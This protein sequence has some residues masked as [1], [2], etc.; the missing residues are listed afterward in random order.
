MGHPDRSDATFNPGPV[1]GFLIALGLFILWYFVSLYGTWLWFYEIKK[2]Y[3]LFALDFVIAVT[4]LGTIINLGFWRCVG[5][6]KPWEPSGINIDRKFFPN[7]AYGLLIGLGLLFAT[8]IIITWIFLISDSIILLI[9]SYE[10]A[11][12]GD[13]VAPQGWVA[14]V[15]MYFIY[16]FFLEFM[17][18]GLFYPLLKKSIGFIPA[19]L[20]GSAV[21]TLTHLGNPDFNILPAIGVLILGLISTLLRENTGSIWAGW[22]FNLSITMTS[23]AL[24][25]PISGTI[26]HLVPP[27]MS[28]FELQG[29]SLLNGGGYGIEAGLPFIICGVILFRILFFRTRSNSNL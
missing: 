2:T 22:I 8:A 18:R 6:T 9:M 12:K 16:T 3:A 28:F 10:Q 5:F 15:L 1:K 23:F 29:P 24:G 13:Y 4:L 7:I 17:H 14:T 11:P 27:R 25:L 19:L 26:P 20:M 21:Y